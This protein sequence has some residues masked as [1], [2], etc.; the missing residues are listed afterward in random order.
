MNNAR[1]NQIKVLHD[2][3]QLRWFINKHAV[4][5]A[6]ESTDSSC[7]TLFEKIEKDLLHH[8]AELEA[9]TCKK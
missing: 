4:K 1:Y 6:T 8:I 5:E 2:L 9:I 7:R 3:C